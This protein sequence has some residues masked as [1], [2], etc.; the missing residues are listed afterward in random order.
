MQMEAPNNKGVL[1]LQMSSN[2]HYIDI[3][4]R[5]TLSSEELAKY[6]FTLNTG[7]E[8]DFTNGEVIIEAGTY[9]LSATNADAVDG[10]YTAPMYSGS[11][12]FTLNA[13]E[14]KA[15]ALDLGMPKNAMVTVALS[16]EFS[17]KYDLSLM[18]LS[19]GTKSTT[20]TADNTIAYFPATATTISYTLVANA[21][22]GSHVQDITNAKGTIT[23]A[24]GTHTPVTLK[25]N[26]IDPNL[27]RIETGGTHDDV[28]E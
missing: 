26:P 2:Q 11:I 8:L 3:E 17:A 23:I 6:T 4:T 22:A 7:Q 5:A 13:G 14:S 10:G 25:L 18:T 19:D 28:F 21:K 20:L 15:L 24:A 12:D 27:I 1:R 16:D 9:T